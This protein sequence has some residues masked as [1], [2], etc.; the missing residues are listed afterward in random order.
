MLSL[1]AILAQSQG[2]STDTAEARVARTPPGLDIPATRR[3]D[4]QIM[5]SPRD[6]KETQL[7]WVRP[8]A[9]SPCGYSEGCRAPRLVP[10]VELAACNQEPRMQSDEEEDADQAYASPRSTRPLLLSAHRPGAFLK[11]PPKAPLRPK[12]VLVPE[13]LLKAGESLTSTASRQERESS[14][15]DS[16]VP[17]FGRKRNLDLEKSVDEIFASKFRRVFCGPPSMTKSM[18]S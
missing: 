10:A 14:E 1:E 4:Q 18:S 8:V 7:A 9:I 12:R 16:V 5:I 17:V 6:Q 15:E 11:T 13:E 3:D 2:S